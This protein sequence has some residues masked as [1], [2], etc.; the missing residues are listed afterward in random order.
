MDKIKKISWRIIFLVLSMNVVV[1]ELKESIWGEIV[2][3]IRNF[4]D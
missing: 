1:D 3:K 2:G 4:R